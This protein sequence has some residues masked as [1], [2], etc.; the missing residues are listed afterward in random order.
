MAGFQAMLNGGME[1]HLAALSSPYGII[2]SFWDEKNQNM[3]EVGFTAF[4]DLGAWSQTA[5]GSS[6][7]VSRIYE[8]SK[9]H[10]APTPCQSVEVNGESAEPRT[11]AY[12]V[13]Q[14]QPHFATPLNFTMNDSPTQELY[15]NSMFDSL[16][17]SNDWV[18]KNFPYTEAVFN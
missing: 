8:A 4:T 1:C 2:A 15:V 9:R 17:W 16:N 18:D 10:S 5:I 7:V 11:N 3:I 14:Y 6:E 13:P 12:G